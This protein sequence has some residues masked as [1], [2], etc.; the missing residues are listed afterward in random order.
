MK[1]K[2]T[3]VHSSSN[4]N[5]TIPEAIVSDSPNALIRERYPE[6][7]R[8]SIGSNLPDIVWETFD[9]KMTDEGM[10]LN[11]FLEI[12]NP[13]IATLNIPEISFGVGVSKS[14]LVRVALSPIILNHG[15]N[16]MKFEI[17]V[18]FDKIGKD[19]GASIGD[20]LKGFG[21]N[22]H[23]PLVLKGASFAEKV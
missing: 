14:E 22:I 23:G 5:G 13:T 15:I 1:P 6:S 4:Y 8:I 19:V 9:V 11:F 7:K 10:N 12:E 16:E 18:T 3:K 20:L 2:A 17:R 21:L